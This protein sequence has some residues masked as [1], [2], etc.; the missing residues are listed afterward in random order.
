MALDELADFLGN[1]RQVTHVAETHALL[2]LRLVRNFLTVKNPLCDIFF[3][4]ERGT[5]RPL[6]QVLRK[7]TV[8]PALQSAVEYLLYDIIDNVVKKVVPREAEEEVLKSLF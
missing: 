2:F 1:E 4:C 5:S 3:R 7:H 8:V 6:E